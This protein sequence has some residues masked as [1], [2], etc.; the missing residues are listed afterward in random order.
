M[1]LAKDKTVLGNFQKA[2]ELEWLETNGLGGWS[3]STLCGCHTRRYHGL[4]MAAIVPPA[5]RMLLLSKL[6]ET[7]VLDGNRFDLGVNDYGDTLHPGGFQYLFSFRKEFFPE[8]I[9]EVPGV[10]IR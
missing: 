2:S 5:E 10:R 6:D 3:G 8:W 7:I 1:L 9:Y 4:L